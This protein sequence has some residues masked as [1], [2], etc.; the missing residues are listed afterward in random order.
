MKGKKFAKDWMGKIVEVTRTFNF[1]PRSG[2]S[3]PLET[4]RGEHFGWI[5]VLDEPIV[6]WVVGYTY[7]RQGHTTFYPEEGYEWRSRGR[8]QLV[9]LVRPWPSAKTI[10]AMPDSVMLTDLEPYAWYYMTEYQ[11]QEA[12]KDMARTMEDQCRDGRGQWA[13][14]VTKRK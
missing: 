9:Y 8:S 5:H 14:L 11:R 1:N 4:L 2:Y 7:R 12:R 10:D 13:S 6:G 3:N